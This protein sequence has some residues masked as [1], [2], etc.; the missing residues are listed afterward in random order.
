MI[1]HR[2]LQQLARQSGVPD[3]AQEKDYVLSWLLAALST[4][5]PAGLV[6]K[7]GTA[8]R[9]CWF[10]EYRYSEDLD[11]TI[12]RTAAATLPD[13]IGTWFPWI[14]EAC[15]VS[16]GWAAEPVIE[17]DGLQAFV[18][19][20]GPL[21]AEPRQIK[22]DVSWDERILTPVAT[23]GL[24]SPY[25]DLDGASYPLQVYSLDEIW[26]EKARSLLQRT[27]PRDV[28]DLLRLADQR[29]ERP[30]EALALFE[31]KSRDKGLDPTRLQARLD[32]ARPTFSRAWEQRLGAQIRAVPPFEESWRRL[33]RLFRDAGYLR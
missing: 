7:G 3:R 1:G 29:A 22:L 19:F 32:A 14:R 26:A 9:R 10:D 28:Y 30:E 11:F 18:E 20:R 5:G 27:E 16:C 21:R 8:L 33:R 2:E 12:E 13:A 24:R 31:A 25:T 17:G 6:F 23:K 4:T 15:G